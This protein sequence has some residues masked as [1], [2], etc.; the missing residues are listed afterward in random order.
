M[1]CGSTVVP[2]SEVRRPRPRSWRT[3]C[4]DSRERRVGYSKRRRV[5]PEAKPPLFHDCSDSADLGQGDAR[6]MTDDT[7]RDWWRVVVDDVASTTRARSVV[8]TKPH[9]QTTREGRVSIETSSRR[10]RHGVVAALSRRRR[11]GVDATAAAASP[12]V[13]AA[14]SSPRGVDG[15]AQVPD[16]SR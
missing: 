12:R 15:A 8:A 3:S 9:V 2:T 4:V 10:C 7:A 5:R 1:T 6:R 14:A 13:E 11:R 16:P